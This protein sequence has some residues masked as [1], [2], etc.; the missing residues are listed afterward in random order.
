MYC[1][2]VG[3]MFLYTAVFTNIVC[4]RILTTDACIAHA[5]ALCFFTQTCLQISSVVGFLLQTRITNTRLRYGSSHRRILILP[6]TRVDTHKSLLRAYHRCVFVFVTVASV[7][8]RVCNKPYYRHVCDVL[9]LHS[10][11]NQRIQLYKHLS[12]KILQYIHLLS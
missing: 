3:A 8:C 9:F 12:E 7:V 11:R 2:R 4:S 1:T 6:R 5:S 10:V